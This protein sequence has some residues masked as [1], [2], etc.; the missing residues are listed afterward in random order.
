MATIIT[1]TLFNNHT[2]CPHGNGASHQTIFFLFN[3]RKFSINTHGATEN[4]LKCCSTYA[5]LVWCSNID[6]QKQRIRQKVSPAAIKTLL[7]QTASANTDE[8]N[9]CTCVCIKRT[10]VALTY[11]LTFML[12]ILV[13]KTHS[14]HSVCSSVIQL[15]GSS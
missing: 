4:N 11:C 5:R 14:S 7:I 9:S 1:T 6:T 3:L 12:W 2:P 10:T 13:L 15:P 8:K